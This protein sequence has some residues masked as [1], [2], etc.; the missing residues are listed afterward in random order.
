MSYLSTFRPKF[1]ETIDTTE[2][3][4]FEFVTMQILM[5]KGKSK[6]GYQKCF[7]WVL[8]SKHLKKLLPHLKSVPSNLSKCNV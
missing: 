7:I 5:L 3:S 6:F 4:T 2:I 8:L 1:E